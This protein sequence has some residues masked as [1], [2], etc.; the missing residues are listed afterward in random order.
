MFSLGHALPST[1][2]AEGCPSFVQQLHWY[3]CMVRLLQNLHARRT[4]FAFADR[5]RPAWGQ[6]A[7]E[8]SRFSCTK[9]LGVSGV[10]DYAGLIRGSR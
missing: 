9:L 2:S 3:Y 1:A 5:S 4:A 6:D 10:Y 8:V 7:L